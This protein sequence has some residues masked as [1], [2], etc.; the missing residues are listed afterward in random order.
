MATPRQSAMIRF[1]RSCF[2]IVIP[3]T[4]ARGPAKRSRRTPRCQRSICFIELK[5]LCSNRA[6]QR[7]RGK[8]ECD[9]C[10][11]GTPVVF[12]IT[13]AHKGGSQRVTATPKIGRRKFGKGDGEKYATHAPTAASMRAHLS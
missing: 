1:C 9:A 7:H 12:A 10:A 5:L 4:K 11:R 3:E 6:N 2:C 8:C 13:P